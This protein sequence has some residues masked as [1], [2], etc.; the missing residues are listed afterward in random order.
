MER[1]MTDLEEAESALIK[2]RKHY[3]STILSA[4]AEAV[5]FRDAIKKSTEALAILRPA[6]ANMRGDALVVSLTEFHE[7]KALISQN[8]ELV[9]KFR[10]SVAEAEAAAKGA[11]EFLKDVEASLSEVQKKLS[12][13]GQVIPLFPG[14]SSD[15]NGSQE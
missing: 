13:Y 1:P 11:K 10:E 9:V 14:A 7:V 12:T 8:E 5:R 2:E 15:V 6:Y 4:T 3:R